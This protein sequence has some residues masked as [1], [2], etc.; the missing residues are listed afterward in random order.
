MKSITNCYVQNRKSDNHERIDGNCITGS[1][2]CNYYNLVLNKIL[3]F[4]K[5][6]FSRLPIISL[7]RNKRFQLYPKLK[8]W[9][10]LKLSQLNLSE[11]KLIQLIPISQEVRLGN[12]TTKME[13]EK[14][15]NFYYYQLPKFRNSRETKTTAKI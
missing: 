6:K 12:R 11:T 8:K 10:N 1:F 7:C 5:Q 2:F 3:I 13:K 14:K 4:P 15:N 9:K